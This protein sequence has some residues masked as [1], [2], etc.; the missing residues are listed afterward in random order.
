MLHVFQMTSSD[1][2]RQGAAAR[3]KRKRLDLMLKAQAQI[4]GRKRGRE[5]TSSTSALPTL[6]PDEILALEPTKR[7]PTP[8]PAETTTHVSKRHKFFS[9]GEKPPKDLVRGNVRVRVLDNPSSHLAPKA[10]KGSKSLK[11]G[12][13]AGRRGSG[14]GRGSGIGG[15]GTY[16]RRKVGGGFGRR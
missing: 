3:D 2:Y 16:E 4:A 15:E 10:G 13:L 6:L 1:S 9:A 7:P 5:G 11:E 14:R 12:W 8:P